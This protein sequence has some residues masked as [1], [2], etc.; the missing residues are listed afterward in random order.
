MIRASQG[1]SLDV[2]LGYEQKPPPAVLFHGTASRFVQSIREQGLMKQGRHHVHLS[3]ETVTAMAVGKR[4]G[5]P[6]LLQVDAAKMHAD[7]HIF[8]VSENSVWLTEAVPP[9]YILFAG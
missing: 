1:H 3:T 6:V 4:Y 9:R 8:F 2:E 7:G 5:Q